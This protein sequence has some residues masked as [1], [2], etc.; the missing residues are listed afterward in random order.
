MA[1]ITAKI[2]GSGTAEDPFRVNLPTY[3]MVDE[4]DYIGK[5]VKIEVPDDELTADKTRP[6]SQ[7][8]REK[9]RGQPAWDRAN[10]A[11]DV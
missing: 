6:D 7:K 2:I 8:L 11:A 5:T 1:K 3:S 4:P 10:V 9:Y